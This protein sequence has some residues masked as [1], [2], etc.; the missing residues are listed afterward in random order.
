MCGIVGYV[1]PE[2]ALP[3]LIDGLRTLGYRGY[4]SAG[5]G[6]IDDGQRR[7]LSVLKRA[8]KLERLE[9]A[10][11]SEPVSG[12]VGI[13][14]TRWA[15]HGEPTDANAHPHLDCDGRV[16]VIHNGIVENF[17]E[18]RARLSKEGHTFRSETDTEC[19]AHLLETHIGDGL[20][21]AVR[22]TVSELEGAY[23]IVAL[24]TD[25][26]DL[27]VGAKVASPLVVG[28]GETENLL[29]SDIPALLSRA[30]SVV[31][32]EGGQIVETRAARVRVSTFDGEEVAV[33]P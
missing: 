17:P 27:I 14:H 19:I 13:G 15:T 11:A 18:L 20:V 32:V 29:A 1:G 25:E 30:R 2:Q 10:L 9:E 8:G 7:Q 6:L 3:I 16:A 24:S 4:D 22:A 28:L 31:P 12:R 5:V 21:A 26:P 33:E 23:A